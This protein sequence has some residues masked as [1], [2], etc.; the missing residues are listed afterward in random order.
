MFRLSVIVLVVGMLAITDSHANTDTIIDADKAVSSMRCETSHGVVW[1]YTITA[2]SLVL[3]IVAIWV[4]LINSKQSHERSRREK[5]VELL[6]SW[7]ENL[8]NKTSLAKK[9]VETLDQVQTKKLYNHEEI[10]FGEENKEI[11]IGIKK[12][13][14][15]LDAHE[16]TT[17]AGAYRLTPNY[18]TEL[19]AIIVTYL[20]MLEC[21]LIAWRHNIADPE[22]IEEEF[23]YMMDPAKQYEVLGEFRL[24]AGGT[25]T[26]PSIAKFCEHLENKG[27]PSGNGRKPKL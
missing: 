21:I 25:N 4:S 10:V 24:A 16:E 7:S 12:L 9:Y 8:N 11:Y 17:I 2:I 23:S 14:R 22:I 20:N 26:Y 3:S 1:Q 18:C 27:K 5:A 19:R 6:L 15:G 13:L